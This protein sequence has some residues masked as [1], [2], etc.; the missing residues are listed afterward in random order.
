M[1]DPGSTG[2]LKREL[3][4]DID[5]DF[6]VPSYQRGYRWGMDEVRRLLEDVSHSDGKDYYLQPVVVKRLPGVPSSM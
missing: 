1:T 2:R 4:G 3:V 5:G 6:F